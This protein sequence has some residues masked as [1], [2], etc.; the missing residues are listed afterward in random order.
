MLTVADM[1]LKCRT[2]Q[3]ILTVPDA[4]AGKLAKCPCGKQL[5]VPSRTA[6]ASSPAR[7][8]AGGT[9]PRRPSGPAARPP[10]SGV[11]RDIFSELTEKDFQ[12]AGP[13]YAYNQPA[14]GNPYGDGGPQLN[15]YAPSSA[16]V[17]PSAAYGVATQE[18]PRPGLLV[19]LGIA[20]II[21]VLIYLG[22][23][24]LVVGVG[25]LL[26]AMEPDML[27]AEG[28]MFVFSLIG[29]MFL[30]L[31]S[32]LTAVACFARKS[33]FWYVMLFSY[34]FNIVD[35]GLGLIDRAVSGEP[36][37]YVGGATLGFVLSIVFLV[38][39]HNEAV[40]AYYGTQRASIEGVLI[41]DGLGV[42]VGF[43]LVLPFVL[44]T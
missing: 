22:F 14:G 23:A 9:S 10:A 19:F 32:L 41:A 15:Q 26:A 13:T 12:Q 30:G 24:A 29:F 11:D 1:K 6:T 28:A 17:G 18:A 8:R 31:L 5:R 2:C 7:S 16:H 27:E 20:N 40:R 35:R 33:Y 37:P 38:A 3:T 42:L 36:A 44:W 4:A 34:S 25:G 43:G 39:M 21:W